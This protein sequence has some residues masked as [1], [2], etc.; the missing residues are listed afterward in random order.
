MVSGM[1]MFVGLR[2]RQRPGSSM[3]VDPPTLTLTLLTV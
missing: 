1:F 2:S 3:L